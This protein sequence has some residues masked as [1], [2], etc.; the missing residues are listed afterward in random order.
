MLTIFN[1]YGDNHPSF[2]SQLLR[3]ATAAGE[4]LNNNPVVGPRGIPPGTLE[5]TLELSGYDSL[6]GQVFAF[7]FRLLAFGAGLGLGAINKG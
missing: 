5:L 7:L 4:Q 3:K 1:I 6:S 2:P